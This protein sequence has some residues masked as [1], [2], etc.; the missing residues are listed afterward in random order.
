MEELTRKPHP[1]R[2]LVKASIL[3]ALGWLFLIYPRPQ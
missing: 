2:I 3:F 1:L